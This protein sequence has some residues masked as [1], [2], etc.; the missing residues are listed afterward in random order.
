MLEHPHVHA[1]RP[2]VEWNSGKV[3]TIYVVET[4]LQLDKTQPDYDDEAFNDLVSAVVAYVKEH[5]DV[6]D[7]ARIVQYRLR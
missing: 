3:T 5:A 2:T 4:D 6:Y 1:A 7:D